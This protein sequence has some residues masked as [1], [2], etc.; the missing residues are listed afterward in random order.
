MVIIG[1]FF[2][3]LISVYIRQKRGT[4]CEQK[5]IPFIIEYG[6]TVLLIN[7][8]VMCLVNFVFNVKD[9]T[10]TSFEIVAFFVKYEALAILTAFFLPYVVEIFKKYFQ[11]TFKIKNKSQNEK[12]N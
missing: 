7:F 12:N 5:A 6:I 1:L 3:A 9:V 4:G 11:I 10:Q 8:L 2:P